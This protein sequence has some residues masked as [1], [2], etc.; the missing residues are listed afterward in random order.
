MN[1][2]YPMK[3]IA[4]VKDY[5]WG[6]QRLAEEYGKKLTGL[7]LA[8]SWE[9][10]CHKDGKSIIANGCEQGRTLEDWWT[11]VGNSV[12]GSRGRHYTQFPLLIKFID[13][14]EN[15][16]IQVHPSDEYALRVEGEYGKTEMWYV[17]DAEP[18]ATI[19]YGLKK[20]LTHKEF[21]KHVEDHT[22]LDVCN[23]IP[24][25]KG[26]AFLIPAGM[27]HAIGKGVLICEVQ[28]NS[29][30][31]YRVYDYDRRDSNGNLRELHIEKANDVLRLEKTEQQKKKPLRVDF[32]QET[33]M[34]LSARCE[35]FTN[36]HIAIGGA[37]SMCCTEES[38]QA[39]SVLDGVME[40]EHEETH[41]ALLKGDTIFIPA[42]L[43]SYELT[44]VGNFLLTEL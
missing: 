38:F 41:L 25:K 31:T 16:S 19:I 10:A 24:V 43:G 37:L 9:L 44:G 18:G 29:N 36:W 35:Y 28:Q 34:T 11:A 5:L 3:L 4:P 20:Q 40:L 22:L 33:P 1:A 23:I 13:A 42:G 7:A 8:E 32:L 15:L 14:K 6:G 12:L 27:L 26:D 17:M 39:I 30:T 2:R 21:L